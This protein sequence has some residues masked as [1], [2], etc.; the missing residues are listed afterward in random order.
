MMVSRMLGESL[1]CEKI[2][3]RIVSSASTRSDQRLPKLVDRKCA[4]SKNLR[5]GVGR[6]RCEVLLVNS[7]SRGRRSA[8]NIQYTCPRRIL[9]IRN[10]PRLS[11]GPHSSRFCTQPISYETLGLV[12][13]KLC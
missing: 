11:R 9:G 10:H 2:G 5:A 7:D 1:G 3:T 4:T 12:G 6:C 8:S 13:P